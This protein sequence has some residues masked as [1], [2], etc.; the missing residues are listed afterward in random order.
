MKFDLE[1]ARTRLEATLRPKASVPSGVKK[2][3]MPLGGQE[4][5]EDHM[6]GT[7]R[8]TRHSINQRLGERGFVAETVADRPDRR[9]SDLCDNCGKADGP[10]KF[11]A[12]GEVWYC[13]KEWGFRVWARR[14]TMLMIVLDAG[15]LDGRLINPLAECH[16]RTTRTLPRR[17]FRMKAATVRTSVNFV[18][19]RSIYRE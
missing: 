9:G 17:P 14:S 11:A 16:P 13:G 18:G 5:L 12:C 10:K 19:S 1:A 2:F 15:R 3:V 4:P 7:K 6:I 8:G